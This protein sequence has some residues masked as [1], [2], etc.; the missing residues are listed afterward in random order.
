MKVYCVQPDLVWHDAAA[1][2]QRVQ[3]M[4]RR[5]SPEAGSLVVLPETFASGFTNDV[6]AGTD[7]PADE[8]ASWCAAL[9]EH[10]DCT[11][12]AGLIT[13]ADDG[14]GRNQAV[15][16][17]PAGEMGRYTKIHRFRLGG[18]AEQYAPGTRSQVFEIQTAQAGPVRVAPLVCYDLRFPETFREA[19]L[20]GAEV[21]V[22]IANW[23]AKRSRHWHALLR[24]RAI[25]NQAFVVGVNRTGS[26]PTVVY[27]GGTSVYDPDGQQ[28]LSMDELPGVAATHLDL[29][30]LRTARRELPFLADFIERY[31]DGGAAALLASEAL[32]G[33]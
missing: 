32:A 11:I 9:A 24:A 22:V 14:R 2:R 30:G 20:E 3:K 19:A 4:I 6:A 26:D 15:V 25:E 8:T 10:F 13:T 29:E 18:E 7:S 12:I 17:G 1:N 21:Y 28:L 16:C 5:A 27:S 23:P 33:S 31:R